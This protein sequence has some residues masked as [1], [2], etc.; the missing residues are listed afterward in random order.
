MSMPLKDRIIEAM[1]EAKLSAADLARATGKTPGAVTQWTNGLTKSL[2]ADT[3]TKIERATGYRASWLV[4]G[5]GP[6]LVSADEEVG[7]VFQALTP[8]EIDFLNDYRRV[9]DQDRARYSAEIKQKAKEL[10][11]YLEQHLGHIVKPTT[12]RNKA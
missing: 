3:A 4:D 7:K 9:T 6:K 12:E 11:A 10:D 8:E 1:N 2:K 5:K